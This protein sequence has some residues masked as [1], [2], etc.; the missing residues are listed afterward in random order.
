MDRGAGR[1]RTRLYHHGQKQIKGQCGSNQCGL[2]RIS[3]YHVVCVVKE[4]RCSCLLVRISGDEY[5]RIVESLRLSGDSQN[6]R[7]S[8]IRRYSSP[9]EDSVL[10]E[11]KLVVLH[12]QTLLPIF[13]LQTKLACLFVITDSSKVRSYGRHG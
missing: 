8:Q 9:S 1:D 7:Y 10:D 5:R 2:V 11:E 3:K 6:Q 4:S 13:E 12:R